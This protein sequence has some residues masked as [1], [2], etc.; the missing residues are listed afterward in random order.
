MPASLTSKYVATLCLELVELVLIQCVGQT[1]PELGQTE[2]TRR[3][4][5]ARP[6]QDH[7][8]R[9]H[10]R[11]ALTRY[12]VNQALTQTTGSRTSRDQLCAVEQGQVV[13][14]R[15]DDGA[16]RRRQATIQISAHHPRFARLPHH[17]RQRARGPQ[18]APNRT[19]LP[20]SV[21]KLTGADQL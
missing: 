13:Q 16:L 9:H 21:R 19:C 5:D 2:D 12:G 4:R 20:T 6:G 10:L 8:W 1:T 14:R 11:G 15:G 3:G 18:Y 7:A 17:L